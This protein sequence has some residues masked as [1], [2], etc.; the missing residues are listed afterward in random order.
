[1]SGSRLSD[2]VTMRA[3]GERWRQQLGQRPCKLAPRRTIGRVD[4]HEVVWR[5][6]RLPTQPRGDRRSTTRRRRPPARRGSPGSR[7]RRAGRRSTNVALAAPRD[8]AS[9]ASAP[10]PANRSSTRAPSTGPR[11]EKSASRTRS[12]VGRV[13]RPGGAEAAGR[14]KGLAGDDPHA[15]IGSQLAAEA[16]D[17]RLAQQGS[18]SLELRVGLEQPPPRSRARSEQSTSSSRRATRNCGRPCWRV[19]STSPAPRRCRSTSASRKPSR[20]SQRLQ[21]AAAGVAEQDAQAACSPRPIRPRSWWS[22]EIP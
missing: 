10:E 21:A 18:G 11:I 16:R 19:P 4:E 3:S 7:A 15:G 22:C 5:P 9:I 17:R 20:C 6:S 8:S 12:E 13:S 2:S 14:D 1:M